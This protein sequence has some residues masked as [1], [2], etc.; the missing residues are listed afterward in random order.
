MRRRLIWILGIAA[1]VGAAAALTMGGMR[2]GGGLTK[3][4]TVRVARGRIVA[5]V[6]ASGTLSAL[7]TVQVGS[8]VSGRIQAILVDFNSPVRRGQVLARIDPQLFGAAVEQARANLAAATGNLAKARAQAADAHRQFERS[9]TL[10]DQGQLIAQADLDTAQANAQA[11]DAQIQA[12]QGAVE[13][14]RAALSQ[15]E[16][17]LGYTTI[18]S[19]IDGVVI[20]R[21]VDVG[22]TVAASL[23]APTLF[24]IAQ[25][26]RKMQ[27]DT[28]VAEADVGKLRAGMPT[29]FNVDAFPGEAFKGVIRQIRNAPQTLQNVVTYDAVIDVDNPDL[30]LRPGMTA[31]VTFTY[32]EKDGVL[33]V[34]NAAL[35]FR[36]PNGIAA[37]APRPAPGRRTLWLL[38]GGKPVP[39]T[40][41]MGLSDGTVTEA[42]E[43]DLHEGDALITEAV[44]PSGSNVPPAFRR[45]L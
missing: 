18:A 33:K 23:Q 10:A 39:V 24:T 43:G 5:R 25:D 19:S 45:P 1:L 12:M 7:V 6:T 4:E 37:A 31:N 20:S 29:A 30:K 32:A 42:A 38:Q 16:V 27:V 2:R 15:A 8:Q 11:A 41:G 3:Y 35:R 13:Q 14:A 28:N 9:R 21:N 22:Q 26:L 44:E 17:N 36:P 34:P 40:I